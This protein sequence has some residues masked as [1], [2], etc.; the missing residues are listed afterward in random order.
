MCLK[1]L[2]EIHNQIVKG[3]LFEYFTKAN[4]YCLLLFRQKYV[5]NTS[6]KTKSC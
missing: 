3:L 6:D 1:L 4:G 2:P 5:N